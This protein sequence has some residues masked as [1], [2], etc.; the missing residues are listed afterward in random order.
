MAQQSILWS[1]DFLGNGIGDVTTGPY[2]YWRMPFQGVANNAFLFRNLTVAPPFAHTMPALMTDESILHFVTSQSLRNLSWF[3]SPLFES[4]HGAVHNWVGGV[5]ADLPIS[6]S[7]PVFFMHHAFM[8]CLWEQM[9]NEQRYNNFNFDP[10]YDYPNDSAA[11]GVGQLQPDGNILQ[12]ATQSY[13]YS[14]RPMYPFTPLR[15][16][17]GLHNIYYEQFYYCQPSPVCSLDYPNCGSKFLFCD[18]QTQRCA[19]RLQIGASCVGFEN[20]GPCY[21][22]QCCHG[23]CQNNCNSIPRRDFQNQQYEG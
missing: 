4:N 3:V 2:S 17:D 23:K 20:S 15:N 14:T 5:M 1:A 21:Q 9:R 10:Q 7:D 13:H 11:L 18:L 12:H 8:D 22:S 19:P 6:P 16:I